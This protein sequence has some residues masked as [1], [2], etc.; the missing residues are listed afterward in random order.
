VKKKSLRREG[1]FLQISLEDYYRAIIDSSLDMI[2]TV[3]KERRIV[4]FNRSAQNTFGYSL[5][6]VLGKSVDMLYADPKEGE[7]ISK[8]VFEKGRCIAEVINKRKNGELFPSLISASLLRNPKGEVIGVMGISRDISEMKLFEKKLEN[9]SQ[10]WRA[11]FDAL[12]DHL[13]LIDEN[14]VIKRCNI[15]F[16]NSLGMS[17]HE[18]IGKRLFEIF[19]IPFN[20]NPFYRSRESLKREV[21]TIKKNGK[22][23]NIISE[24]IIRDNKFSGAVII[25]SDITEIIESGER[26][27]ALTE[28]SPLG[29]SLLRPDRTF[30]YINPRFTELFGYTIEDIPDKEKWFELAYPEEEYRKKVMSIWK[31]DFVNNKEIGKVRERDLNVRCKDGDR[32]IV[33]IRS[34][35]MGDG[36]ILQTYEDITEKRKAE[37]ILEERERRFRTLIE[38]ATDIISMFDKEGRVI[39]ISPSV[40]RILG[41]KNEDVIGESIFEY[42]HP[43]EIQSAKKNFE[44]I[45]ST[46]I[47]SKPLRFKVRH[48][49]GSWRYLEGVFNNLLNEPNIN[50]IL[51]NA[52]DITSTII[53]EEK[54]RTLFEESKDGIYI[55]DP[56][57]RILDMNPAGV[58][59]LGFSSKE[60][61]LKVNI[62]ELYFE[63]GGRKKYK[64][65]MER[66]GY[67]KDFEIVLKK[68]NGEKLIILDTGT[69]V[70]D[71]KGK[72]VAYR[73][74]MRDVTE[75]K[76]LEQQLLHAQK[77]DAIGNL[78]GGIAHDFNNMLQVI[79]GFTDLALS[80][81]GASDPLINDLTKIKK[82]A[83]RASE[84]VQKLLAFS[85]KQI[86]EKKVVNMN[87]LINEHIQM[88]RRLIPENIELS[89]VTKAEN[90]TVFV[91]P[92]GIEQVIMNIVL[93]ARD[94]MPDGG[95]IYIETKNEILESPLNIGEES[96]KPGEYFTVSIKDTGIG[97]DEATLS[98]IFEPFFS[99]K[100]RSKGVGLGLSVAWGIIKQHNGNIEVY[101]SPGK[102]ST[103]KIYLPVHEGEETRSEN[104]EEERRKL[105][106]KE[107][108]L[109][110]EDE[111]AI[112]ELLKEVLEDLGYKV[113]LARDGLE[114]IELLEINKEVLDLLILDLVMPKMGGYEVYKKMISKN[115]NF[116]VIFMT[117]YTEEKFDENFDKE[118]NVEIIS[119]PFTPDFITK[120]VR[121]ILDRGIKKGVF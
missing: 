81:L 120:K 13:I 86:L 30:E 20:L 5:E 87:D 53:A 1:T 19:E 98:R 67:V 43:D 119:K 62:N 69:V 55:T 97:M 103:F 45:A 44:K 11:T 40:E 52:R 121:E 85:R 50:A 37:E 75:Y 112:R 48:K 6:E 110:A 28:N 109:I 9:A 106:G 32:K 74:I 39:Y 107:T 77:M 12:K 91:D 101:S 4:E 63:P 61:L 15:S 18:I 89:V 72:I 88:V 96:L 115:L 33:R 24:P 3:D 51:M 38:N 114:A 2:I 25:V 31:E 49:N 29:I 35:A 17:F 16:S 64:E 58:E 79:L 116:P 90:P 23:L 105:K 92:V 68:K 21:S 71:E 84:L 10:E 95:K 83:E 76:K 93:N 66:D 56:A 60:E 7:K 42:L 118:R 82:T 27:K 22:W 100:G 113:I 73:G 65:A 78:A 111:E 104:R 99:T 47:I 14:S 36:K 102:G 57:G 46:N 26:F 94:A 70:R 117:G 80:K 41:Y 108:I 54:Y 34:V 59:M 8:E